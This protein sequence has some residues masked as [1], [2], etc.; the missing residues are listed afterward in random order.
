V[1]TLYLDVWALTEAFATTKK[2]F[3]LQVGNLFLIP[4]RCDLSDK[5]LSI[6]GVGRHDTKH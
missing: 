4:K 3:F 2:I 5:K 6:F 1:L